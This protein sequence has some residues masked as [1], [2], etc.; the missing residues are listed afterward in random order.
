MSDPELLHTDHWYTC[1]IIL[2]I[3][4]LFFNKKE[5]THITLSS[6]SC[7]E[8]EKDVNRMNLGYHDI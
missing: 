6:D 7:H 3:L 4:T 8:Y 5:S 1:N 2:N